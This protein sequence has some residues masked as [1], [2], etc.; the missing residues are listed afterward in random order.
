MIPQIK[1]ILY[2]TDLSK[3]ARYAYAYAASLSERYNA[4]IT[5]LHV[6]EDISH[7]AAMRLVAILGE[8]RWQEVQKRNTQEVL[9]TIRVRLEKFC[10]EMDAELTQCAFAVDNIVIRKGEPVEKILS[11]AEKSDCDLI[12][13]GTHGQGALANTMMGSTARR[14]IRRSL[15]PVLTVR[16]PKD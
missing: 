6:L 5:I 9:D 10:S 16:L 13:M 1:K 15:K 11:E 8:E 2:T 7:N 3:N 12:V 14:V 4:R